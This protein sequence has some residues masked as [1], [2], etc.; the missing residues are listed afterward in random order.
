MQMMVAEAAAAALG[1]TFVE[2]ANSENQDSENPTRV[3]RGGMNTGEIQK[4]KSRN[5]DEMRWPGG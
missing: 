4:L 3:T 1:M 5:H 2:G